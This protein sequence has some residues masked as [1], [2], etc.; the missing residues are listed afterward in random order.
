VFLGL[1]HS[2]LKASKQTRQNSANFW[3]LQTKKSV[4]R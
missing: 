3:Q 2:V 1:E 4:K